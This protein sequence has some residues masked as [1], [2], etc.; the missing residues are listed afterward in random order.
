M[1]EIDFTK[2]EDCAS[3]AIELMAG[4]LAETI[5]SFAFNASGVLIPCT[6]KQIKQNLEELI[7]QY[8][9]ADVHDFVGPWTFCCVSCCYYGT[10]YS[11]VSGAKEFIE[12]FDWFL[13]GMELY[14]VGEH[15]QYINLCKGHAEEISHVMQQEEQFMYLP[16]TD[17]PFDLY[18]NE[19]TT[20]S[21]KRKTVKQ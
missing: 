18:R 20:E 12:N 21:Q 17:P 7:G 2:Y 6:T 13:Y 10:T 16:R 14:F 5:H 15:D 11:M 9:I 8:H 19:I 1:N 3:L 4:Q